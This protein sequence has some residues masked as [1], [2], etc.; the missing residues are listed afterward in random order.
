M[1]VVA[2][3]MTAPSKTSKTWLARPGWA[4]LIVVL[5]ILVVWE[6]GA[7]LFVSPRFMAP[8]SV[9]LQA[10]PGLFLIPGVASALWTTLLELVSSFCLAVL[11]GAPLG[12]WLGLRSMSRQRI[13]P[14]VLMLY[15]VPQIT[16]L[17]LIVMTFGIGIG[18]KIAFG[19]SHAVFPVVFTISAAAQSLDHTLL[20][21]ARLHGA[22][23][24]QVVRHVMLPQLAPAFFVGMRLAMVGAV[25]GVLFAELYVSIGGIGHF[26]RVFSDNFQTGNLFALVF[27]LAAMAVALNELMRR[28]EVRFGRWRSDR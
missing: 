3:T 17:P 26:T 14:I 18:S 24:R 23:S 15:A 11:I 16:I 7:R 8:P 13:M 2:P 21:F 28:A 10:L 4:R 27:V 19:V 20:D 25:L 5:A 1:T 22:S 6:L 12:L 9:M